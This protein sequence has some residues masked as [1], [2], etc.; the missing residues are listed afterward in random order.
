MGTH[1]AFCAS[2]VYGHPR[3]CI[4]RHRLQPNVRFTTFTTIKMIGVKDLI[5]AVGGLINPIIAILV[6]VALLAFFWGLAKFIFR[7]GGDEK[8]V[9]EGKNLMIWGVIALFVMISIWG[10]IAFVYRDIGFSRP[11]GIPFLP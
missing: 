7:V 10:I 4:Q 1:R 11:F 3:L 9:E 5:R 6:G 8:A 2:I